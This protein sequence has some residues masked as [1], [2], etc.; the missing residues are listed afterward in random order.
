VYGDRDVPD[1]Q[2][3]IA[4]MQFGQYLAHDMGSQNDKTYEPFICCTSTGIYNYCDLSE[5]ACYSI[6]VPYDDPI[7]KKNMT[8]LNFV[9][10]ITDRDL[11]CQKH[12]GRRPKPVQQINF[13]TS[14]IDHSATYANSLN[15][16]SI[17][18]SFKDGKLKTEM[19]NGIEWPLQQ[20]SEPTTCAVANETCFQTG[21]PRANNNPGL[22]LIHIY[23]MMEHNRIATELKKVNPNW[24]DETLFQMARSI[25]IAIPQNKVL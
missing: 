25:N 21:D 20:A 18:R 4:N 23:F 15:D 3:T 10:S 6:E 22:I 14:F 12:R 5:E 24:G 11:H 7:Y 17:L 16:L 9:R 1:P 19:Q 8:C 13:Q 2:F